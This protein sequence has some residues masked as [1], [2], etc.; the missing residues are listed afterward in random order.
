MLNEYA[1]QSIARERVSQLH[2]AAAH[3]TKVA[4]A[5]IPLRI[6]LGA[7]MIRTGRT[8]LRHAPRRPPLAARPSRSC[9]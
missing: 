2:D 5:H 4:E 9:S 7:W 8:L 3:A 1:L 6:R